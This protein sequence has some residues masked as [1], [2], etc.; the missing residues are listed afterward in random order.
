MRSEEVQKGTGPV[1][2][3]VLVLVWQRVEESFRRQANSKAIYELWSTKCCH[4]LETVPFR[5]IDS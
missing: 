5:S 3:R 2:Q 4:F 1:W